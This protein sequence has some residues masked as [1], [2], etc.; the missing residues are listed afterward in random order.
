MYHPV[1]DLFRRL[2]VLEQVDHALA[3]CGVS[4]QFAVSTSLFPLFL[5]CVPVENEIV[6]QKNGLRHGRRRE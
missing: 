1:V 2:S 5:F 3:R 6:V 4:D